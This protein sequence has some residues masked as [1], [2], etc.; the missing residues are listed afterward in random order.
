MEIQTNTVRR[1]SIKDQAS[2]RL[3]ALFCVTFFMFFIGWLVYDL[4][5]STIE[6]QAAE[7]NLP[8]Q[9]T[10]VT[11]DP[12]LEP[13]LKK[14]LDADFLPTETAVVSDPFSDRSNISGLTNVT[15][16]QNPQPQTTGT[17]PQSVTAGV[18]T[19]RTPA[20]Q[21]SSP[22]L[23][24]GNRDFGTIPGFIPPEDTRSRLTT[25][26]QTG[27]FTGSGEPEPGIFAVEDLIPVGVVS[28]GDQ[29]QEV[30]FYS[31]AADRTFSFP[32]G[33][34]FYDAWLMEVRADGVVFT[35]DDNFRT[36]RLKSWGRSVKS[37]N[38]GD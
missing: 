23:V 30:M 21:P 2:F 34:R 6:A 4:F 13:E 9:P 1:I 8:V 35:F 29:K 19:Q 27:R 5:S 32:L 22:G 11:I 15:A 25:W 28:G 18:Q 31:Q 20:R 36:S 26:E 17:S 7:A 37:N 14:V 38:Q 10:V 12:K 33:T 16:S 3:A 24:A